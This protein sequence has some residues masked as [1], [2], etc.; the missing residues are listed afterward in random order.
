MFSPY[1]EQAVRKG[2]SQTPANV[3]IVID[4]LAT[5]RLVGKMKGTQQHALAGLAAGK[6][7]CCKV[8]QGEEEDLRIPA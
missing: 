5:A 8:G 3:E 7:A 4:L 6:S 2:L 1:K